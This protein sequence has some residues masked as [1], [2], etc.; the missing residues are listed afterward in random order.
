M[1]YILYDY[2]GIRR[3]KSAARV[4]P[5]KLIEISLGMNKSVVLYCADSVCSVYVGR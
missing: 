4:R 3:P 5:I 1:E 2:A